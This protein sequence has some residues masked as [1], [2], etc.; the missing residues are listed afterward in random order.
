MMTCRT[1]SRVDLSRLRS[2]KCR[3]RHTANNLGFK[4][5]TTLLKSNL[6]RFEF[7]IVLPE[8]HCALALLIKEK[9]FYLRNTPVG[10]VEFAPP[11]GQMNRICTP[12]VT[13][14]PSSKTHVPQFPQYPTD[15]PEVPSPGRRSLP[16]C[17]AC[18]IFSSV[19]FP[20]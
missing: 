11:W 15:I 8:F 14:Y 5:A 20:V 17:S 12:G 2:P 18:P 13:N 4:Y 7:E 16:Q 1:K 19:V 9:C 6:G 10:F 3:S